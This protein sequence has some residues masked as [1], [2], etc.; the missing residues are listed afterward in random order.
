MPGTITLQSVKA[1]G[2]SDKM[3]KAE[4]FKKPILIL[5]IIIAMQ[6]GVMAIALTL[7]LNTLLE[8]VINGVMA[9]KTVDYSIREQL[10]DCLP[11]TIMSVL[12]GSRRVVGSPFTIGTWDDSIT[13][14][15]NS[16]GYCYLCFALR[17]NAQR[18]VHGIGFYGKNN[19]LRDK[20]VKYDK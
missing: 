18:G 1:M 14:C 20:G 3:L 17:D 11:A 10:W 8:F 19:I 2:Y 5:S 4:I 7:P 15:R 12:M 6:Y 16:G 9:H 13:V